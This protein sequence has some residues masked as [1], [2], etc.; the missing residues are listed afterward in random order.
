MLGFV[1]EQVIV[2]V[3]MDMVTTVVIHMVDKV[4]GVESNVCGDT[5]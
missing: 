5:L 3:V 2:E 1:V 4:I